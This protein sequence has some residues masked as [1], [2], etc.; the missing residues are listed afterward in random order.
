MTKKRVHGLYG[1]LANVRRLRVFSLVLAKQKDLMHLN[2]TRSLTRD[3]INVADPQ[4]DQ[5]RSKRGLKRR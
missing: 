1:L 4:N 3:Q 2:Q 5:M